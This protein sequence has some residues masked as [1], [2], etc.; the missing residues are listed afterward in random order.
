MHAVGRRLLSGL[1]VGLML[2]TALAVL[3]SGRVAA[4]N[5]IALPTGSSGSANPLGGSPGQ[6][7][8]DEDADALSKIDAGL[9][10]AALRPQKTNVDILLMTT[11]LAAA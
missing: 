1:V 4:G 8:G 11:D 2:V 5:D 9:Q 7:T 6:V 3:F 10:D